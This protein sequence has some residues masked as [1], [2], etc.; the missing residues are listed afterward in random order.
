MVRLIPLPALAL[1]LVVT[2]A[3]AADP[4]EVVSA[5][6]ALAAAGDS[7]SVP[8]M[9]RARAQFQAM[10]AAEPYNATLHLWVATATWRVVPFLRR[11]PE[12][13]E[14]VLRDGLQ[15]AD[16]A[17]RLD[18]KS[19]EAVALKAALQGLLIQYEPQSMMTLGPEAETGLARAR[20]LAPENPRVWFL[21]GIH[22][23]HKPAEFGG[24]PTVARQQFEHAITLFAAAPAVDSTALDWGEADALL[25][26]GQAAL[27]SADPRAAVSYYERAL[28]RAPANRWLKDVLLPAARDSLARVKS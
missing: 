15:H 25:W 12:K 10:A 11:E 28:G 27:R 19:G 8:A 3:W 7:A 2:T 9:L 22:S 24:S 26:A 4:A 14:R 1:A 23:L 17:I 5:K 20:V 21:Q 6:R 13:A 16:D 18:A